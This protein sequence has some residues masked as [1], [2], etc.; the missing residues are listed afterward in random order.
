MR[1]FPPPQL[2]SSH[3]SNGGWEYHQESIDYEQSNQWGY[4]NQDNSMEYYPTPQNNSYY[5]ANGGWEYQQGMKEYEHLPEPQHDS[6]CYNNHSHCD[7][8]GKNQR[9]L[10][11]PYSVHQEISS[12]ECAFNK[13]MQDCPP[14]QQYDPYC[15]EFNNSSSCAWEDK[16]QEVFDSSYPTY[17]KPSSLELTF[18]SFMQNCPISPPSSSLENF[19]SL[20]FV[21]TQSFL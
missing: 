7:W 16:N 10:N 13:F 6:Y 12:L 18:N 5:Y 11:D 14:I 15:D 9:D 4:A 19:S 3:Y 20:D 21:S 17:Q 2:N 8:E 1:Y